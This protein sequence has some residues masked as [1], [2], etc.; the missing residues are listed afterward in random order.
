MDETDLYWQKYDWARPLA[1]AEIAR[2]AIPPDPQ[3]EYKQYL[4]SDPSHPRAYIP[5]YVRWAKRNEV[6]FRCPI[7]GWLESDWYRP[8]HGGP[9]RKVGMLT[10]DHIIP[11]A[12]GGLTTDENI[13]AICS[14]AN[15]KKAHKTISD[16]ELRAKLQAAYELVVMPSDLVVVLEKYAITQY[17]VG[18]L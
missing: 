2:L 10:M 11:G 7:T 15:S 3:R 6:G 8:I 18:S 4:P 14:L 1:E 13:R 17:K 5:S 12:Q 16:E 9:F